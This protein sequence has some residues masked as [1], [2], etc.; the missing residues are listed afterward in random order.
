ML[1]TAA[2]AAASYPAPRCA[3]HRLPVVQLSVGLLLPIWVASLYLVDSVGLTG[4]NVDV[5]ESLLREV[6]SWRLPW[7]IWGDWNLDP[8]MV[9]DW[10]R[11]AGGTVASTGR[12]T[13][14][15]NELD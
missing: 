9:H 14:G 3:S 6:L 11:K 10:A 8:C 5:L 12:P 13:S 4:P 1:S 7:V 2:V 15:A